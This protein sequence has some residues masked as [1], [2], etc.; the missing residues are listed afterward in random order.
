MALSDAITRTVSGG[1]AIL[2][3]GVLAA[4][5]C[6][7]LEGAAAPPGTNATQT[8][9]QKVGQ[10]RALINADNRVRIPE[11]IRGG[12]VD[13][14]LAQVPRLE[15]Y[16]QSLAKIERSG[17]DPDA[18]RFT[19]NFE[20]ILDSYSF[21]CADLAEFFREIR[22]SNA[23]QPAPASMPPAIRFGE[24]SN[25]AD[26]IGMIDLML[27]S[28]DRMDAAAKA[29]AAFLQPAAKKVGDDRDRLKAAKA[30]HH[31]F[32]EKL[33]AEFPGRYPGVDWTSRDI[34]P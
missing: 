5:G 16:K 6:S 32:T 7:H 30:A 3:I 14:L 12:D 10:V 34:L 26:T 18:L 31:E 9:L 2:A 22:E 21:V 33:K 23:R 11:M 4:A 27:E 13:K 24:E 1:R 15:E 8:Y 17:V 28:M 25:Q 29:A 20:A 19:Q